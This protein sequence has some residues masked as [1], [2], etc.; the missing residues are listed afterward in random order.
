MVSFAGPLVVFV[1]VNGTVRS[2]LRSAIALARFVMNS[3]EAADPVKRAQ[4]R[5]D[6]ELVESRFLMVMMIVYPSLCRT[7]CQC[8]SCKPFDDGEFKYLR[9]DYSMSC[10]DSVRY[11]SM[12]CLAILMLLVWAFGIPLSLYVSLFKVNLCR[13]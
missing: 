7:I 1:I 2:G 3:D 5:I 11:T 10:I 13:I 6:S 4:A 12:V 9:V 8:F